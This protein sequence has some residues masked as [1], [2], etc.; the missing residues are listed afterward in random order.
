MPS[1]VHPAQGLIGTD[2]AEVRRVVAH[3]RVR[4]R[5]VLCC[6]ICRQRQRLQ[7]PLALRRSRISDGLVKDARLRRLVAFRFPEE[8]DAMASPACRQPP[9]QQQ[10]RG[11]GV[12]TEPSWAAV[13]V[14]TVCFMFGHVNFELSPFRLTYFNWLQQ[15]T[16]VIFG[17]FYAFLFVRTRSL[18]GPILAHNLLNG[19]V[20]T[21]SLLVILTSG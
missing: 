7:T 1:I 12:E 4:H 8:V 9:R 15:V 6:S 11:V 3:Q 17:I 10:Y 14:V 20:V 19:V 18:V 13:I 21:I 16:V 5:L 2:A